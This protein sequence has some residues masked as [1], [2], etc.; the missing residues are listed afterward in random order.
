[1]VGED[2]IMTSGKELRRVHVIRHTIEKKMTQVKGRPRAS[3]IVGGERHPTS[4]SRR[5]SR[6]RR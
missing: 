4:R 1:M 5:R 2:R 3:R 6:P